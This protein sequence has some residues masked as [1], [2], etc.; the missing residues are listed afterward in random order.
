MHSGDIYSLIQNAV[1]N[2]INAVGAVTDDGKRIIRIM[3][4]QQSG[5][6]CIHIENY[7]DGSVQM[8]FKDGVPVTGQDTRY[9]GFGMR[10][11]K[12]VCKKYGG[13]VDVEVEEDI[14]NLDITLPLKAD[15]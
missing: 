11:I 13:K 4:R 1:N 8:Q 9:H 2:A 12:N 5:V 10:S 7:F 3:V 15:I 14:F 6:V